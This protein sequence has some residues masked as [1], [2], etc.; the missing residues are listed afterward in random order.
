MANST[1]PNLQDGSAVHHGY[2]DESKHR[3]THHTHPEH[4]RPTYTAKKE[5]KRHSKVHDPH[6]TL[7]RCGCCQNRGE[8]FKPNTR[9]DKVQ[10]HLGKRHARPKSEHN[11]GI[12]CPEAGCYTLFIA[13]SCLDEH[14]RQDHP[15]HTRTIPSQMTIGEW[16]SADTGNSLTISLPRKHM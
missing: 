15:N 14:C 5:L 9:K 12:R 13:G 7:W 10:T 16:M 2:K 8:N 6:A 4:E 1:V 11:K 3:C